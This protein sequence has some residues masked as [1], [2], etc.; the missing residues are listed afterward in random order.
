MGGSRSGRGDAA[1]QHNDYSPVDQIQVKAALTIFV[2]RKTKNGERMALQSAMMTG[3]RRHS[4]LSI[5]G[6]ERPERRAS[7]IGP[8]SGGG[9]FRSVHFDRFRLLAG[10]A[11]ALLATIQRRV[12]LGYES[13]TGFHFGVFH[14]RRHSRGCVLSYGR[15]GFRNASRQPCFCPRQPIR[16]AGTRRAA[17]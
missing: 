12:P 1:D 5:H 14:P 15:R 3:M 6:L 13:E 2:L 8:P 10:M 11:A 16:P 7:R 9:D 4:H 17:P